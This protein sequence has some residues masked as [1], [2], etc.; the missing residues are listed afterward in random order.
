M[1]VGLV[2]VTHDSEPFIR[3]TLDA[4]ARQA[5]P[6]DVMVVADNASEDRTVAI[7]RE[8]ASSW[9]VPAR[10]LEMGA[11][12]GFSAANNRGVAALGPCDLV[13]LLNPDAFPDPGWL[14]A[15]VAAAAARPEAGSFASRL[16]QDDRPGRLDGAGDVCHASGLVWRHG[17]GRPI[18]AVPQALTSHWVFSACAAAA[19]YR[20]ADWEAAGGMD[21]RFFCYAED[22]DLGFRLQLAG[23]RCWYVADAVARHRGSATAGVGSA[24]AVYHGHRNM[25]WMYLKNMPASLLWRY[26]PWHLLVSAVG[27]VWFTARGRGPAFARAKWDALRRLPEVLRARRSVQAARRVTTSEVRELL[28]RRSLARRFLGKYVESTPDA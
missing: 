24:F 13:A 10:V 1:R 19:L 4:V 27:A 18:D 9:S 11:N 6:P 17:H 26:L 20:R 16:M 14:S 3:R 12:V 21:D 7:A 8:V 2:I 28:D 22:T 23:R 25:E 5:R 15:L